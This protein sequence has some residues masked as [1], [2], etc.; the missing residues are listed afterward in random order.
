[1]TTMKRSI[2]ACATVYAILTTSAS[3][4][5]SPASTIAR[6]E[7]VGVCLT[8]PGHAFAVLIAVQNGYMT[9]NKTDPCGV[10]GVNRFQKLVK[11][12]VAG[13]GDDVLVVVPSTSQATGKP[14]GVY[15]NGV[16]EPES[17]PLDKDKNG[18]DYPRNPF[19]KKLAADEYMVLGRNAE[20]FD[21]RY[22]GTVSKTELTPIQ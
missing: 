4:A 17:V 13:P 20:S 21:S 11:R 16:L 1:M 2:L 8:A 12:V 6:G 3:F 9:A 5:Q 19:H 15:V 18:R 7:V 14:P 10:G 22:F